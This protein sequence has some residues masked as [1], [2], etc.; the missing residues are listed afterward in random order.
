MIFKWLTYDIDSEDNGYYEIWHFV[1]NVKESYV[2]WNEEAKCTCIHLSFKDGDYKVFDVQNGGYL[3][4][5][6]GKTIERIKA[7]GV[8]MEKYNH[9]IQPSNCE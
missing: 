4:S 8:V 9:T 7:P 2:F 6:S 5:D 3:L 1:D